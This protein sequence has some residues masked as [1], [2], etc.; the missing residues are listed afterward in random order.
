MSRIIDFF[1]TVAAKG[2]CTTVVIIVAVALCL[3]FLVPASVTAQQVT[4][5]RGGTVIT[6]EWQT[7]E[8]GT[9]LIRDGK[10][11]DV[12]TRVRIPSG[13]EIIDA[14]GKYVMPGLIDAMSYYGIRPT[15]LNDASNPV[16]PQNRIIHAYTPIGDLKMSEGGIRRDMELLAGGITTIYIAPGN[17]QVVGGQGAIVK[18][19]GRTALREPAAMDM[20]LGDAPKFPRSDRRTPSTRM[21]VASLIR[22][23][24][25]EAQEYDEKMSKSRKGASTGEKAGKAPKRNPGCE[26]LVRLLHGEMPARVE[27]DLA[28][29]LRTAM[30]IAEEFGFNLV[31]DSGIC[32]YKLRD[33]LAEMNIPVVLR[34]VSHPYRP[35]VDGVYPSHEIYGQLNEFNA[36]QLVGAGVKIAFASFGMGSEYTVSSYHGR[37]LLIE[38]AISTGYGL[39][40]EDALKAVTINAA[41]ILGVDDQ[42]GSIR[43]GK[44]ADII[45]LDGPPLDVKTWVDLVIVDGKTVYTR[46]AQ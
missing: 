40:K 4:A 14:S 24:L 18:T 23:A 37:W 32:A 45:I 27:A 20:T 5:V 8:S 21:A 34:P 17:K 10:I 22:K 35:V 6:M 29:D 28:D 9:V 38:A 1:H 16:T 11:A 36:A 30:R 44:D 26:A 3:Q 7:F 41:E 31:I 25:L 33:V 15:D 12:G 13:A 46:D 43:A 19:T 39:S 42:V 2:A